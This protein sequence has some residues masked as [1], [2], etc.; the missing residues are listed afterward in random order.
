MQGYEQEGRQESGKG[1]QVDVHIEALGGTR[2]PLVTFLN[3]GLLRS[4]QSI[5]F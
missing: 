1:K 2:S 5:L 3:Y 4:L